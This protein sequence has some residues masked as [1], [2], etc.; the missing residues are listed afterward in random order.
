V[1]YAFVKNLY[2]SSL[3]QNG[4]MPLVILLQTLANEILIRRRSSILKIGNDVGGFFIVA[5]RELFEGQNM[6]SIFACCMI[7]AIR[8]KR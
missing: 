8:I 1:L 3:L 5:M 2:Q 6:L 7:A 4:G